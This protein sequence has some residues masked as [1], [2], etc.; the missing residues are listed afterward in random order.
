MIWNVEKKIAAWVQAGVLPQ[1]TADRLLAH[2]GQQ[3][4]TS[5]AIFGV[6]GIGVVTILTG[7]ISLV[8]ANWDLFDS[9]FKL[10]GYVLLQVALGVLYLKSQQG[11]KWVREG[12]LLAFALLF[13]AGI[14]LTA[15][16]F[17]LHGDGWQAILFWCALTAGAM[18]MAETA[19][20]PQLWTLFLLV[21]SLI[22]SMTDVRFNREY[23][24]VR[25]IVATSV[26]IALAALGLWS[27]GLKRY[28]EP[29]RVATVIWGFG[30]VAIGGSLAANLAWAFVDSP[31]RSA[32]TYLLFPWAATVVAIAGSL[33]RKAAPLP[34]RVTTA[35]LLFSTGVLVT[36]PLFY[37]QRHWPA[38]LKSVVGAGAFLIIW[39]LAAT[40][41]ARAGFRRIYDLATAVIALRF[42][43]IY[44]EVFGSL[45]YTGVGLILSGGVILGFAYVWT[46]YRKN[47]EKLLGGG[48]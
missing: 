20:L 3:K 19:W 35:C 21:A 16:V 44:F 24:M 41:A 7:I 30:I 22:W 27:Q 6:V 43:V 9:D 13:F 29:F 34:L 45:T 14:G 28:S 36:A 46:K 17:Q 25:P 38:D 32:G 37:I 39:A 15:Q 42:V 47:V 11:T 48:Q 31:L 1:D 40:S 5:W 2:E 4:G 10:L 12:A 18:W 8:A 23:E 26:P 33:A